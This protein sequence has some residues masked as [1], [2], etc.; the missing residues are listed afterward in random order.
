MNR[1]IKAFIMPHMSLRYMMITDISVPRWSI[2]SNRRSVFS[3]FRSPKI[4]CRIERCPELDT[5]RNSVRACTSPISNA[6]HKVTATHLH[7]W[8]SAPCVIF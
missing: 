8:R 3:A 6:N 4:F 1:P 2:T 5:G 7:K